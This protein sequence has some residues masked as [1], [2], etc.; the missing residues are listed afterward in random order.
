MNWLRDVLY[1][2]LRM[3]LYVVL[4]I[5]YRIEYV[6]FEKLPKNGS[7]LIVANHLSYMD[8]QA[9]LARI[10]R[11]ISFIV[12]KKIFYIPLIYPL[13]KLSRSIPIKAHKKDV[14]MA[15][16]QVD[17]LLN[18]G[19]LV[20][21]FP[22]GTMSYTGN[23]KRFKLGV[24]WILEKNPVPV[25][26]IAIQGFWGS[27]WSRKYQGKWYRWLPKD[28]RRSIVLRMGRPIK[29]ELAKIN[30][31]QQVLME[32]KDDEQYNRWV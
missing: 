4:R 21:I 1:N 11:P 27:M 5:I 22:E 8:S 31:L 7:A 23:M 14:T 26:P 16:N 29:P 12:Y 13:M 6:G 32:L 19:H 25:Y 17:R 20:C 10:S 15:I 28:F 9:I 2:L 30:H 18:E 24:E 3:F